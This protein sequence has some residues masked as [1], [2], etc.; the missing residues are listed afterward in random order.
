MKNNDKEFRAFIKEAE[1]LP[2]LNHP[3]II[4]MYEIWEEESRCYLVMEYCDGGELF[5]YL[6]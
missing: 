2:P 6:V 5:T 1:L 4:K 3:N